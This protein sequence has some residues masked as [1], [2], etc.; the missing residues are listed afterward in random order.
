MPQSCGTSR[1]EKRGAEAGPRFRDFLQRRFGTNRRHLAP[2][3]KAK[4]NTLGLFSLALTLLT[5]HV[6]ALYRTPLIFTLP[7]S[8]IMANIMLQ[9]IV[10][11][12]PN[13]SHKG[14]KG[15]FHSQ[16]SLNFLAHFLIEPFH[17]NAQRSSQ[18]TQLCM[19]LPDLLFQELDL[20]LQ[21]GLAIVGRSQLVHWICRS[22]YWDFRC[23][24]VCNVNG[25]AALKISALRPPCT[26][27]LSGGVAATPC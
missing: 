27:I 3:R 25:C 20:K 10:N 5:L 24:F 7:T 19:Y 8:W 9:K 15:L 18:Y 14:E 16:T 12:F 2:H 13:F 21:H 4:A 1:W 22:S 6:C 26:A 11:R 17:E 23:L